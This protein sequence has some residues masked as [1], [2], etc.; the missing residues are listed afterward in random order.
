MDGNNNKQFIKHDAIIA[1]NIFHT[2]CVYFSSYRMKNKVH[3]WSV[4][5]FMLLVIEESRVDI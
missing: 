4:Q 3:Q 2:G 5:F 1:W